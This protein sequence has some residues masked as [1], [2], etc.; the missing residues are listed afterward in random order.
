MHPD[1]ASDMLKPYG[2]TVEGFDTR[3]WKVLAAA[4]G[5]QALPK[6]LPWRDPWVQGKVV[7]THSLDVRRVLSPVEEQES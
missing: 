3:G 1:V 4:L 5:L 2:R 7:A 6:D